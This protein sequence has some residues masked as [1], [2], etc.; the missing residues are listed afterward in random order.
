MAN[1]DNKIVNISTQPKLQLG[2]S[3]PSQEIKS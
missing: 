1:T 2:D 3:V